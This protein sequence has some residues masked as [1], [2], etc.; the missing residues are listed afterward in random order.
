VRKDKIVFH[1]WHPTQID[2]HSAN[3]YV[4]NTYENKSST[5]PLAGQF[6]YDR[7]NTFEF[8][9]NFPFME[10][11]K[12]V[13]IRTINGG[14]SKQ[15]FSLPQKN[16]LPLI[17]EDI[18][19][20][21]DSLPENLLR[22][23]IA[24]SQP[25]KTTG[26][27]ENIKLINYKG[28]EIEGAIFNNVYEL[29][30][31]SQK[32]LTIIFDPSRVKTDLIAN[33][34]LGRALQPNQQFQIQI[35]KAENIYGQKLKQPYIKTFQVTPKDTIAPNTKIWQ[36]ITPKLNSKQSLQLVFETPLDRMSLLN[37]I[38]VQDK[39][40]QEVSGEISVGNKEMKWQF[41]PNNIWKKGSYSLLINS[42]LEDPSGN[43]L[44]G[45]FDHK[46]GSLKNKQ[47]GNIISHS[48]KIQEQDDNNKQS[49]S[50]TRIW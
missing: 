48:F 19:P 44:N 3:I 1:N 29:W 21:S 4:W 6:K 26:N 10:N 25:M 28:I 31:D 9:P 47:E 49:K 35:N 27:L 39:N 20:T 37:R 41:T 15:W 18:Y 42:R 40:K 7:D 43:N 2:N 24:F 50:K 23:Y 36:L 5:I 11:T 30:D 32:Q 46:V 33:K 13:I 45:L 12:Y 38:K 34:K 16:K 22:M 17:V 8:V 14:N